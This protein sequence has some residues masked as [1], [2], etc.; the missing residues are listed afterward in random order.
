MTR[1]TT[2]GLAAAALL[3]VGAM[4]AR[5]VDFRPDAFSIEGGAGDHGGRMA[6]AGLVWDWDFSSMR[7]S[8]N[9]T[10]QTELLLNR[11]RLDAIGGGHQ[12]VT[13]IAL[14]PVLRMRI[15]RGASPWFFEVGV[16][17]SYFN[18]DIAVPPDKVF[19]T[20]WNFYDVLG[21]GYTYGGEGGKHEVH[22]RYNH[23]SNAGISNPNPGQNFFQL[24]YVQRF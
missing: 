13:Q 18:R 17:A 11:W 14:V 12:Q 7:R 20:R 9:L 4:P 8:A 16:G 19:S 23:T 15:D 5:A 6:G 2:L 21:V 1:T 24:R 10:A 22:L 3:L